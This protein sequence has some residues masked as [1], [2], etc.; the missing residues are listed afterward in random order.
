MGKIKMAKTPPR[1][2]MTPMVDLFFLLLIFFILTATFRPQEA[3][4][5]DTPY[6]N[7]NTVAPERHIMTLTISK[8]NLVFFNVDNGEDSAEHLRAKILRAIGQYYNMTFT[9][10]EV[11][12]F[13]GMN[14]FSLPM[15]KM[16]AWLTE[17]DSKARDALNTGM[18]MDSTDNQLLM[19]IRFSRQY[20]PE[21][22]VAIK[23]DQ[24]ADYKE[25][26]KVIDILQDNNVNKFNLTTSLES[27]NITL[28][29]LK[30]I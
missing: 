26:K 24:N 19:W 25:V 4:A 14:S 23:G 10:D 22:E 28:E 7:S 21:F 2:D 9:N 30:D 5:V 3:V 6:S 18:P 8:D 27:V 20:Y 1:I 29:N 11:K 12:K 13:E 17:K 16:K 15:D